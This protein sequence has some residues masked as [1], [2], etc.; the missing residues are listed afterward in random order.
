MAPSEN[1]LGVMPIKKLLLTMSIPMMISY[2]IQALYNTVDSIFVA[3]IS[4]EALT[5]ISLSF[6]MQN[7]MTSVAVGTGVGINALVPRKLSMKDNEGADQV[8]GT[9]LFLCLIW[10]ILFTAIGL[11]F[12]HT[13][14]RLQTDNQAIVEAGT[15]YLR[16]CTGVCG[17]IFFGQILE[18][19]LVA[20]GNPVLSMAS[21]AAGALTNLILDPLLIFGAGPLPRMGVSGAALATVI[22]QI[23]AAVTA[24]VLNHKKNSSVSLKLR[25]IRFR[26]R[27]AGQ[28]Y[29]VGIPSMITIGLGSVTSFC[30][31]QICLSFGVTVTALYGIWQK[32]QSF[33]YMPLFGMNNG[34]VPILSYNFGAGRKDRVLEARRTALTWAVCL[35]ILLLILFELIPVPVLKLFSASANMLRLGTPAIRI[36]SLA[37]PFGALCIISSTSFQS[38]NHARYSLIVNIGRQFLFLVGFFWILSLFRKEELLWFAVPAAEVISMIIC[39]FLNRRLNAYL[40]AEQAEAPVVED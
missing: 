11:L 31:N 35:M 29:G 25:Y 20:T 30:I 33:V 15:Q 12:S 34:L 17:G 38:L 37:M 23:A 13:Y 19:L 27:I 9:A 4:E 39:L 5:A 18:K 3:R 7:I 28:I 6:P 24:L 32:L 8:A 40:R 16:I 26:S 1:K 10:T 22:G 14:F 21:M 36:L 2:F